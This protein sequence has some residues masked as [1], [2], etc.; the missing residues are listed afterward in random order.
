MDVICGHDV[1]AVL[2]AFIIIC[3]TSISC[4]ASSTVVLI[5]LP[6]TAHSYS[7]FTSS[8]Y[9][10]SYVLR[11]VVS[12]RPLPIFSVICNVV[13]RPLTNGVSHCI[14]TVFCWL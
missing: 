2:P 7:S 12:L 6:L 4:R 11:I 5:G 10:S 3:M 14:R 8:V 9:G 13:G 1:Y